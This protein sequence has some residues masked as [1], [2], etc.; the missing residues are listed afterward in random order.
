MAGEKKGGHGK[1]YPG[2]VSGVEQVI[3]RWQAARSSLRGR[4]TTENHPK[5]ILAGLFSFATRS[6]LE[7]T[8]KIGRGGGGKPVSQM[9]SGP[10]DGFVGT[11]FLLL[12][13]NFEFFHSI[14]SRDIRGIFL[15]ATSFVRTEPRGSGIRHVGFSQVKSTS[16]CSL[17]HVMKK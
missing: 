17:V 11:N 4:K 9:F 13:T 8:Q 16:Y 15:G 14:F 5:S 2:T 7:K 10:G 1:R 3:P 12:Y 6:G